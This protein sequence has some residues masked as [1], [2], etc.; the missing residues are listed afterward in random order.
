MLGKY[1]DIEKKHYKLWL[2]STSVLER[3]LR[4]A[5]VLQTDLHVRK[6][7][8]FIPK[9]VHTQS[10]VF[11]QEILKNNN[12][13][14]I[15][16]VPGIG[17]T[18]L[19]N[20]LLYSHLESGF[21]PIIIRSDPREG[22]DSF[23]LTEPTVFYYDDFL[24]QTFLQ[25][26]RRPNEENSLLDLIELAQTN[27]HVRLILTTR[28]YILNQAMLRH[29]K[30]DNSSA[31]NAKYVLELESYTRPVK[32]KILYNHLFFSLVTKEHIKFL[33]KAE[34]HLKII[35]HKNYNPRIIEWMTDFNNLKGVAPDKYPAFFLEQLDHPERLWEHAFSSHVGAHSRDLLWTLFSLGGDCGLPQLEEAFSSFHARAAEAH[36]FSTSP[37]D[38]RNGLRELEGTFLSI[39]QGRV[40]F[41]NPSIKD[42]LEEKLL[43][44][45]GILQLLSEASIF[46]QQSRNL[47]DI[48]RSRGKATFR[49]YAVNNQDL[50]RRTMER[51]WQSSPLVKKQ[52]AIGP[53]YFE[54]DISYVSRAGVYL[55][56]LYK[57][58]QALPYHALRTS[59]D[60]IANWCTFLGRLLEVESS[61]SLLV[62]LI[63]AVKDIVINSVD[64][65]LDI[66]DY[67]CL[68][69][70]A[71]T[72]SLAANEVSLIA[73]S[74]TEYYI[75]QS[76][77]EYTSLVSSSELESYKDRL[78]RLAEFFEVDASH[79][80]DELGARIDAYEAEE[81]REYD[82]DSQDD[83]EE[84]QL[85]EQ[86]T[87]L[88]ISEMFNSLLDE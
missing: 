6:I 39:E 56:D 16:G 36:H 26:H 81:S 67:D 88:S 27:K 35:D 23:H 83:W 34:T 79:T 8:S 40:K 52:S 20:M 77:K 72:G 38:F 33:I 43:K 21:K 76:E 58:I 30:F 55:E 73:S 53:A 13:L 19:A 47:T 29:E 3:V 12:Y 51:L 87:S 7:F 11:A 31:F 62:E 85:E 22:L 28:E 57:L 68:L 25:D 61:H 5:T 17:K 37:K 50:L 69:D 44:D 71:E 65:R 32:A 84:T 9:Y 75:Q 24:G 42:F 45:F 2:T 59:D 49:V 54:N 10:F 15:S 74:F 48:F 64:S 1:K 60:T 18:T 14:I 80:I 46:F 70:L 63:S 66:G 82:D 86:Q 4:N 41:H 78:E